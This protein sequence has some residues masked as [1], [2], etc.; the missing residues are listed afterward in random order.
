MRRL[1]QIVLIL[2]GAVVAPSAN[3]QVIDTSGQTIYTFSSAGTVEHTGLTV[4]R[5]ANNVIWIYGMRDDDGDFG[6]GTIFRIQVTGV[7]FEVLH[8]FGDWASTDAGAH[9]SGPLVEAADGIFYGTTT[10]GGQNGTGTLFRLDT[11]VSPPTVTTLYS[12]PSITLPFEGPYGGV[13]V[14]RDS[15]PGNDVLFGTAGSPGLIYRIDTDGTPTGTSYQSICFTQAGVPHCWFGD[16]SADDPGSQPQGVIEGADGRLYGTL[17]RGPDADAIHGRIFRME[18]DG[19]GFEVLAAAPGPIVGPPVEIETAGSRWIYV[20]TGVGDGTFPTGA[21]DGSIFRTLPDGSF[22]ERVHT[23][24]PTIFDLGSPPTGRIV[25]M[26]DQSG[27]Y[28]L[29]SYLDGACTNGFGCGSV[30]RA[31]APNPYPLRVFQNDENARAPQGTPA[32]MPD[33]RLLLMT[34]GRFGLTTIDVL[35]H[36]AT[37]PL[38]VAGPASAQTTLSTP[39]TATFELSVAHRNRSARPL[40]GIQTSIQVSP[41]LQLTSQSTG[42]GWTCAATDPA[43]GQYVCSWSG[44]LTT[45]TATPTH[46]MTFSVSPFGLSTSCGTVPTPCAT[47]QAYVTSQNPVAGAAFATATTAVTVIHPNTGQPNTPP[48]A[49]DDQVEVVG[50]DPINIRVLD[51]DYSNPAENDILSIEI[52]SQPSQGTAYPGGN[53]TFDYQPNA[54]LVGPDSFQYRLID[55]YGASDIATVTLTPPQA[56]SVSKAVIDLGVVRAGEM[57]TGRVSVLGPGSAQGPIVLQTLSPSE[58]AAVFLQFGL[59]YDPAA[60]VSDPRDFFV[61]GWS[62]LTPAW[63]YHRASIAI[64]QV[65]VIRALFEDASGATAGS[66]IVVG[67]S[68]DPVTGPVHA[69]DDQA[70]TAPETPVAIDVLANDVSSTGQ[71]LAATVA[72]SC[73]NLVEHLFDG[74]ACQSGATYV[75][76]VGL[77]PTYNPISYTPPPGFTGSETFYYGSSDLQACPTGNCRSETTIYWARVTVSTGGAVP[78]NLRATKTIV[79]ASGAEVSSLLAASGDTVRF[80]VGAV[81]EPPQGASTVGTTTDP[82][83]LTDT[84]PAGLAFLAAQSDARCTAVGQ[85]VRCSSAAIMNPGD[86]VTFDIVTTVTAAPGPGETRML[87][88][89]A[90]ASTFQEITTA[91]NT[92]PDVAVRVEGAVETDLVLSMAAG[93]TSV[94]AG[95]PIS[96]S[97]TIVNAGS[98]AASGIVFSGFASLTGFDQVSVTPSANCPVP[99]PGAPVVCTFPFLN[100]QASQV[101]TLTATPLTENPAVTV[102]GSVTG[103]EADPDTANNSASTVFSVGARRADLATTLTAAPSSVLVGET[104]TVTATVTNNGPSS[105]TEV[106]LRGLAALVNDFS[107]QTVVTSQGQCSLNASGTQ[108][109]CTLPDMIAGSSVTVT[110]T[111]VLMSTIFDGTPDSQGNVT[112]DATASTITT[113]TNPANDGATTTITVIRPQADVAV[114]LTVGSASVAIGQALT[115]TA[116]VVNHGPQAATGVTLLGLYPETN[117]TNVSVTSSQGSCSV[118][119]VPTPRVTCTLGTLAPGGSAVVSYTGTPVSPAAAE[120]LSAEIARAELDPDGSNDR[121]SATF[122]VTNTPTGP[123]VTVPLTTS[124]GTPAPVTVTFSSVTS[125]GQ[126]VADP[127]ATPPPVPSGFQIASLAYDISTTAAFTPPVTVCIDGTFGASDYLLHYESGSWVQLPNQQRLPAGGPP[128]ARICAD[129]ATFSPFVVATRT[130][131]APTVEAGPNQTLEATGPTGAV[132]TVSATASDPDSDPLTYAWSGACGA[133]NG[134]TASLSCPIGTSVVTLSVSDGQNQP[135]TDTLTVTVQDTIAPTIAIASPGGNATYTV[136]QA[137]TARFTCTDGGSGVQSC[138]GTLADGATV[139]TDTPGTFTFTVDA[140]DEVG[141]AARRSVTYTVRAQ[142]FAF[143]GFFWPVQNPPVVNKVKAGSAIPV[144]FGLGGN[145]G[146][147]IFAPGFPQVVQVACGT[148]LP[149]GEVQETMAALKSGLIYNPFTRRYIYVWKTQKEMAGS[150]WQLTLQFTDGTSASAL[151]KMRR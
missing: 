71:P 52:V 81:N 2:L 105:A 139:P 30:Y 16:G 8:H 17:G 62:T 103:V 22:A 102:T 48:V 44:T 41:A 134:A 122:A 112:L 56:Y 7:G 146:L 11:T 69:V 143:E 94:P 120:S 117:F 114:S 113:D 18:K 106:T 24:D 104:I 59:P 83:T 43:A 138:V 40:T 132:A 92:A 141:N 28:G 123:G 85:T 70:D 100:A 46:A 73:S 67:Q 131:R 3:A 50:I 33:G 61:Q 84:L 21:P 98:N 88:N 49:N 136:G 31:F 27:V 23:F 5:S 4:G 54:P 125:G 90:V 20:A 14:S 26:P 91:D 108:M 10:G 107:V 95:T 58:I 55:T 47:F 127:I 128:F 101:I 35:N 111:A 57:A 15:A 89:Y 137:V 78:P 121:A 79:N 32:L 29:T 12:F 82:V 151:F 87:Y 19:A 109:S 63:I 72:P 148:G 93:N 135:V 145:Y 77:G 80:R 124:T 144:R 9:P 149:E 68:A 129:T 119:S 99:A 1:A 39:G 34:A 96:V 74:V 51:N 130:N 133:A 116:T 86:R 25:A 53:L 38:Q 75:V 126:T 147:D 97:A 115:T 37:D 150:C 64:G 118:V 36:P 13:I 142:T 66:V 76:S 65:S 110:V 45:D 6:V 60:A 140:V 42:D